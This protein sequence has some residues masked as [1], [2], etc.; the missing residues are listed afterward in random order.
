MESERKI[1][2]I[3]WEDI[4]A[5]D[6]NWRTPD[7]GLDWSSSEMSIVRQIGF[8]LDK[9]ENYITII[10]S[11]LPPDYV[12]TVTRIPMSTVKYIKELTIDS[13]KSI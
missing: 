12:G 1:V 2:L 11:Y 5:T 9:D 10:C 4:I 13:F 3:E 7:E 6:S 8:L